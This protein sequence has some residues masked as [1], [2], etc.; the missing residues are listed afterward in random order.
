MACRRDVRSYAAVSTPSSTFSGCVIE[1]WNQVH[2]RR[3]AGTV[4][5]MMPMVCPGRAVKGPCP[6]RD[7][8]RRQQYWAV[9]HP[10]IPPV[11]SDPQPCGCRFPDLVPNPA[12]TPTWFPQATAFGDSDDQVC[13]LD[14]L[15]QNLGHIIVEG[16]DQSLC[17]HAASTFSAPHA[18]AAP[19]PD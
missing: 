14:Q 8:P 9:A 13:H 3:L 7:F 15:H 18:P 10:E 16:N 2:Q 4:P 1:P 5:L 12:Q 17:Q 11:P 19:P 6:E